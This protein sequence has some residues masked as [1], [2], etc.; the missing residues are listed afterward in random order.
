MGKEEYIMPFTSVLGPWKK[1]KRYSD[2]VKLE[3]RLVKNGDQKLMEI[4]EPKRNE[5]KCPA[6]EVI[7]SVSG[8]RTMPRFMLEPATFHD[9]HRP[10]D[11]D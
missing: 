7:L 6:C 5:V 3:A 8:G 2:S 11:K 10:L 9:R 4:K 1:Y